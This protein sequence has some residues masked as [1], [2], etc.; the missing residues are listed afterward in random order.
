VGGKSQWYDPGRDV[1]LQIEC[2][3]DRQSRVRIAPAHV[4]KAG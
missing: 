3:T 2:N 1:V 4:L